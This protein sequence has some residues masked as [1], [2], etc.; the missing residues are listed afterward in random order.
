MNVTL[1]VK[2]KMQQSF[3]H[4]LTKA[5]AAKMES[6]LSEFIVERRREESACTKE[7]FC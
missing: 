3:W 4:I 1:S 7:I 5:K 6:I 2:C